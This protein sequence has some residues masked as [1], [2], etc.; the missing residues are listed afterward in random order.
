MVIF[1][2]RSLALAALL[3]AGLLSLSALAPRNA[4]ATEVDTARTEVTDLLGR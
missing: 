2:R 3:L 1:D 4:T